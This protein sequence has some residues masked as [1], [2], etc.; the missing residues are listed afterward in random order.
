MA[1]LFT[2]TGDIPNIPRAT[3]VAFT[4]T[5]TDEADAA[6]DISS[7]A[8]TFYLK[9][10]VEDEEESDIVLEKAADVSD[11]ANGVAEWNLSDS[12]T[13]V[14]ERS[15]YAVIKWVWSSGEIMI[16]VKQEIDVTSW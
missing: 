13:D 10:A 14:D 2:V 15:Y 7:D 6:I 1:E 9:K 8:L 3:D 11:G 5:L 4:I 12:D 16:P